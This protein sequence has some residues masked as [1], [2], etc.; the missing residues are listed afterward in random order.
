MKIGIDGYEANIEKRVGIGHYAYQL[1]RHIQKLDKNNFYTIFL[2]SVP[3]SDM[4]QE[5][6]N[7]RYVVG[8]PQ[9]FW[10]IRQLPGLIKKN[11][12]DMFFSPT[13]YAPWFINVPQIISIMDLSYLHYPEMFRKK[14]L[15]QLKYMGG[16]SIKKAQKILTISEFSKKEI[17]NHY[18]YPEQDIVVTYPGVNKLQQSVAP[19]DPAFGG[20]I[21]GSDSTNLE[22]RD[23][24]TSIHFVRNDRL[25]KYI[26]FVG[27]IQPRKNIKRLIEAFELINASDTR[28]MIVGKK[29]WLYESLF[30]IMEKSPKRKSITWL[31][32]VDDFELPRLYKNAICIV[33]PSL[34]EGFGIPVVEA[35]NYGCPVVVSN[36]TSLPEVAGAAGIYVDPLHVQSIAEGITKAIQLTKEEREAFI[37]KGKDQARKFTWEQCARK[38]ID[39]FNTLRHP[40]QA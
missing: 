15:L 36:T 10:T 18:G 26:L 14:D 21:E 20:R 4:P 8:K 2:P 9:N 37:K 17:S 22:I 34:Y 12:V 7:W 40:D 23:P 16:Q 39:V 1:L 6:V 11:S 24:S 35:M 38:T 5:S 30:E 28:L 27:T 3:I 19:T 29:G 25:R 31:D 32:Y 13:H 33:L